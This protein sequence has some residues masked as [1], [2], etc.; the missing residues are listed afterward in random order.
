MQGHYGDAEH[1]VRV[2]ESLSSTVPEPREKQLAVIKTLRA[3]L[4]FQKG[5]HKL[6]TEFLEW[7]KSKVETWRGY[8]PIGTK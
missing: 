3:W 5:D 6:A 2:A 1:H 4:L 8:W 7:S